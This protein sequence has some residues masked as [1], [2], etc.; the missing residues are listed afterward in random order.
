MSEF[1]DLKDA[2]TEISAALKPLQSLSDSLRGLD[3]AHRLQADLQLLELC[4]SGSERSHTFEKLD[5]A[6]NAESEALATMVLCR[7]RGSDQ[8][9]FE[10]YAQAHGEANAK[11]AFTTEKDLQELTAAAAK[12]IEVL[13]AAYPVHFRVFTQFRKG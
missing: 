3:K 13:R 11:R 4:D 9:T 5:A 6:F 2:M 7:K 12:E 10:Q 8:R 1:Y